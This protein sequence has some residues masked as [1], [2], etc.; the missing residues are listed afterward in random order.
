MNKISVRC[1]CGREHDLTAQVNADLLLILDSLT[2]KTETLLEAAKA[3]LDPDPCRLDHH[4]NCQAHHLGNPCEQR[5]L[6]EAIAKA[7]RHP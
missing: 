5:L 2:D 1:E 6:R 4:G 7:E 3:A